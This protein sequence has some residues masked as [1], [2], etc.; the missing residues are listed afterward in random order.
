MTR[1]FGDVEDESRPYDTC[2]LRVWPQLL[3]RRNSMA[4]RGRVRDAHD[5]AQAV[6]QN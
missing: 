4:M 2:V 1:T 6:R 3:R 5:L